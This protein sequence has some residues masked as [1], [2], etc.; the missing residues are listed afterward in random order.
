LCELALKCPKEPGLDP[1]SLSVQE[2]V[3]KGTSKVLSLLASDA[4]PT[5]PLIESRAIYRASSLVPGINNNWE[6]K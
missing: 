5:H 3:E 4:H 2:G 6:N 1:E